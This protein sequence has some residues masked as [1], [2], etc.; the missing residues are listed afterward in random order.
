MDVFLIKQACEDQDRHEW[1][2]ELLP[3]FT[4]GTFFE[5]IFY[6]HSKKSLNLTASICKDFRKKSFSPS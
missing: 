6:K 5:Y 1:G 2:S 3:R 4:S